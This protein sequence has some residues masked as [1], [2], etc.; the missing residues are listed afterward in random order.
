M[1][2]VVF[3]DRDGTINND[4]NYYL[5]S[6]PNWKDQVE[7][8]PG[9]I[10]G[11]KLLNDVRDSHLFF[12][13]NQSGVALKGE[14]FDNLTEQRM[15]E[16]N[17]YIIAQLAAE[18]C[19][20]LGYNA[21]PYV[22]LAYVEKAKSKGREVN[23]EFVDNIHPN[24]KPNPG[25][26]YE[27]LESACISKQDCKIYM[28]GDRASD[29]EMGIRAGATSVLVES[30]KTAEEGDREK[31]EKMSGK[32]YIASSFLDAAEFVKRDYFG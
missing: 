23:P 4:D 3:S 28:I 32:I 10:E 11:I 26:L 8:L 18:G 12:L 17:S 22:D 24:I 2:L 6:D 20:V 16:V 14:R 7:F 29:V 21:C 5:G 15:H 27:T 13:T 25:M 30:S 31:V 9:V 1:Q 19:D